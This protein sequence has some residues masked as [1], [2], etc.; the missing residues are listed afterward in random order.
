MHCRHVDQLPGSRKKGVTVCG[1]PRSWVAAA[2]GMLGA[3]LLQRSRALLTFAWS[4]LLGKHRGIWDIPDNLS[5]QYMSIC[6]SWVARI[7]AW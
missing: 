3:L 2:L 6:V 5:V 1:I 4:L 7:A